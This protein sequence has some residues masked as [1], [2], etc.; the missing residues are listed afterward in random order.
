MRGQYDPTYAQPYDCSASGFFFE[1]AEEYET[2]SSNNR[3]LSGELV[4]E[5]ES[6]LS[7]ER[8]LMPIL[9]RLGD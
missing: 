1:D 6:S 8:R 2:R 9:P 7:M 3:K 5:Y 4:E